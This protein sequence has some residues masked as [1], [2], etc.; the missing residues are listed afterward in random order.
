MLWDGADGIFNGFTLAGADSYNVIVAAIQQAGSTDVAAVRDAL[1]NLTDYPGV[2]GSIT[3]AGTDGT[4]A[5]R[6]MGFLSTRVAP[7]TA[8]PHFSMSTSTSAAEVAAL[9]VVA[10]TVVAL[11]V[12]ALTVAATEC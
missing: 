3:F 4:P 10:V 1:A 12:V 9:T 6:V 5:D 11:T 7:M 8:K 2:T